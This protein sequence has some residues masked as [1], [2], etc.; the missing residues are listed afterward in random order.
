MEAYGERR[1][2][3]PFILSAQEVTG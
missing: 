3:A 2:V 1:G